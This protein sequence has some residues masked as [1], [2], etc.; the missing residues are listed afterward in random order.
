MIALEVEKY[1]KN[2]N[3]LKLKNKTLKLKKKNDKK[4][5]LVLSTFKNIFI[6]NI[7]K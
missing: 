7:D 5:I 2:N 6:K 1:I 4:F 3:I